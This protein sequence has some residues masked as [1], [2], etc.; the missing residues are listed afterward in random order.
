MKG[1]TNTTL[2]KRSILTKVLGVVLLAQTLST[3]SAQIPTPSLVTVHYITDTTT[4]QGML[5]R[6]GSST[7]YSAPVH[8]AGVHWW[9]PVGIGDHRIKIWMADNRPYEV[10]MF[11]IGTEVLFPAPLPPEQ[12]YWGAQDWFTAASMQQ[13]IVIDCP[14]FFPGL[15]RVFVVDLV[16]RK[17]VS[18]YMS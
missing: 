15:Y 6:I 17:W 18:F 16:T 2:M 13:Q 10:Y 12:Y 9:Q 1:E 4:E 14:L 7:G 5:A 8:L 3:A 11:L